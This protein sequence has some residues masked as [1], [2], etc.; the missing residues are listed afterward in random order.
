MLQ[1]IDVLVYDIQDIGCRSFTYISTMGVAMEAAAENGIEFIVLDRPNPIGGEKVEGNLVE[2]G[3]ISFVSQFKIPHI[4]HPHSAYFYP[5]SGI[6][7]EL[8]YLSIGVG[9]TIPFQMFAAEWIDAD[10]LADRMNNLNLPGIKFRPMHLKPFYAFGKG[11]HL[12]GVQVHILDY[13]KA[14]LSEVQFYIMQELAALYPAF[15]KENESRFDMFDK[16][17]G[18]NQIRERFSKNYHFDD[19]KDYWYKD[20]EDFKKLSRKYYLYK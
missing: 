6:V 13:K 7:G 10:K 15:C 20:V 18:S 9:Y 11:E 3:Y 4:P 8:P 14:R 2:D 17:C 12:Q 19:I 16:V 1:G 5:L